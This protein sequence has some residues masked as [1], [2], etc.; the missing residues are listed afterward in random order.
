MLLKSNGG[1]FLTTLRSLDD[2]HAYHTPGC[3]RP[4][5]GRSVAEPGSGRAGFIVVPGDG[6]VAGRVVWPTA[7]FVRT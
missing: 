5:I 3:H 2:D 7:D 1:E 6:R 4:P